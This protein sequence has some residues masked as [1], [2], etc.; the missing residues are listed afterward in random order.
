M[1]LFGLFTL[2]SIFEVLSAF[3][4]DTIIYSLITSGEATPLIL[5]DPPTITR[6]RTRST[7]NKPTLICLS[8][9]LNFS[10]LYVN[11]FLQ[12]QLKWNACSQFDIRMLNTWK[13]IKTIWSYF[14]NDFLLVGG[15]V[16][17]DVNH[18]LKTWLVYCS[19]V[20]DSFIVL[21]THL[22]C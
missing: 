5:A 3:G 14:S 2:L 1:L 22:L 18:D 6:S 11:V 8:F 7:T 12:I 15:L 13:E 16:R 4:R 9:I 17:R 10:I 19:L 21:Y 20:Y